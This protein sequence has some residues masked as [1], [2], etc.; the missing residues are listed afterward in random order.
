[1]P[2]STITSQGRPVSRQRATCSALFSTGRAASLARR[3]HVARLDAVQHRQ[4]EVARP[5]HQRLGLGPGGDEEIAAAG[6]L[7]PLHRLARAEPVAVGL[8]RRAA[9]GRAAPM[10]EPVP[11]GDQRVAVESQPKRDMDHDAA[12]GGPAAEGQGGCS[13][14]AFAPRLILLIAWYAWLSAA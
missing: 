5:G 12:I 8:D 3:D 9:L 14:S 10:G 7:Q 11:V 1:M 6:R 2:V 13:R 4:F